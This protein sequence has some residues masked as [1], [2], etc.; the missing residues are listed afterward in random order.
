MDTAYKNAVKKGRKNNN[1]SGYN[2]KSS[3]YNP[4]VGTNTQPIDYQMKQH[5]ISLNDEVNAG[6]W[7]ENSLF[8]WM[9]GAVDRWAPA[10]EKST[11]KLQKQFDEGKKQTV[12]QRSSKHHNRREAIRAEQELLDKQRDVVQKDINTLES[13]YKSRYGDDYKMSDLSKE[14]A[15]KWKTLKE[16]YSGI[17]RNHSDLH[18]QVGGEYVKEALGIG[19]RGIQSLG[20][21]GAK[22]VAL[23]GGLAAGGVGAYSLAYR[24]LSGGGVTYNSR[25]ERD[26]MGIPFV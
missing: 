18:F 7:V 26:I 21:G 25:G 15:A 14:D 3:V 9:S 16:A 6:E 20:E 8:S 22:R 11:T 13:T 23:K 10:T 24:G 4:K 12:Q 19:W 1:H 17:D 2:I 5:T